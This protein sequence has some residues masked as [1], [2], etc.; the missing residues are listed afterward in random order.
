MYVVAF[1]NRDNDHN[2]LG[3]LKKEYLLVQKN[4]VTNHN[5]SFKFNPSVYA[6]SMRILGRL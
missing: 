2:Q 1:E 5:S 6:Q 3:K 4:A